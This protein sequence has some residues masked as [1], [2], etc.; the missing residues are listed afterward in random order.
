MP[1]KDK[2]KAKEYQKEYRKKNKG[3][4]KEYYANNKLNIK[5]MISKWRTDNSNRQNATNNGADYTVIELRKIL[6]KEASGKYRFSLK[7]L[8][9]MLSRT[10]GSVASARRRYKE[11]IV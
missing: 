8:T 3:K 11:T 7:E 6:E 2:E 4:S 5:S 1:Y 10:L 9:L